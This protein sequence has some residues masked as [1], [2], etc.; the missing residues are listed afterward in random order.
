[1]LWC[2]RYID[3]LMPTGLASAVDKYLQKTYWP[4]GLKNPKDA[5]NPFS[6]FELG[7]KFQHML[8]DAFIHS[9]ALSAASSEKSRANLYTK[10]LQLDYMAF[11]PNASDKQDTNA[12]T[13]L[14][15]KLALPSEFDLT[16]FFNN[17][18][19]IFTTY[20]TAADT[21]LKAGYIHRHPMMYSDDV[22]SYDYGT[23]LMY[24]PFGP[25]R[26]SFYRDSMV[27]MG[28]YAVFGY[29]G[30]KNILKMI[31]NVG[32]YCKMGY[33]FPIMWPGTYAV[34]KMNWHYRCFN[35]GK[36]NLT[37]KARLLA[38]GNNAISPGF[39]FFRKQ[40]LIK[41]NPRPEYR[42]DE[43]PKADMEEIYLTSCDEE[44]LPQ[45]SSISSRACVSNLLSCSL[46]TFC[47]YTGMKADINTMFQ[48]DMYFQ[49]AYCAEPGKLKMD[50]TKLCY[51]WYST[52]RSY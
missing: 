42:L 28:N 32:S 12:I 19:A 30:S 38:E 3:W 26:P 34:G 47:R 4:F 40:S 7:M 14:T 33:N 48:H 24:I 5:K 1:M 39:R 43:D 36:Q 44:T 20:W 45:R 52:R 23:N 29:Y 37:V 8:L 31:N 18:K 25:F 17:R 6:A 41:A 10:M 2:S 15:A 13:A 46:Q 16:S 9:Y 11:Y 51:I 49:T 50:P 27:Y 21:D 35:P 22:G